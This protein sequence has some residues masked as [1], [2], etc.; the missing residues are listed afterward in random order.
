MLYYPASDT[1]IVAFTN[2][3]NGYFGTRPAPERVF[4]DLLAAVERRA[5]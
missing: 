3:S 2:I 4:T 1:V 5:L